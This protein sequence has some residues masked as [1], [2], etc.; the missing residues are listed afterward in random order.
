MCSRVSREEA[1]PITRVIAEESL[2]TYSGIGEPNIRRSRIERHV[3]SRN[4]RHGRG[5]KYTFCP[6][7]YTSRRL[8]K[9]PVHTM[10]PKCGASAIELGE[11][12]RRT[13]FA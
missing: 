7:V 2:E 12:Q 13:G 3:A 5:F 1:A 6:R 8:R 4:E 9:I 10:W 11:E